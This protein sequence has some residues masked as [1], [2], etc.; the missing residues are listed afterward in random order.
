MRLVRDGVDLLAGRTVIGS[1]T[2]AEIP[3]DLTPPVAAAVPRE[4]T[5]PY[6]HVVSSTVSGR[7]LKVIVDY[8]REGDF[9]HLL[10]QGSA[11]RSMHGLA[12]ARTYRVWFLVPPIGTTIYMISETKGQSFAGEAL[13][14]RLR[15]ENQRQACT[16]N[17][18][19]LDVDRWIRWKYE[20]L[21]DGQRIQ[22]IFNGADEFELKVRRVSHSPG[23]APQS[24]TVTITENGLSHGNTQGAIAAVRGWWNDRRAGTTVSRSERAARDIGSLIDLNLNFQQLGFNDGEIRFKQDGKVQMI[25]PNKIERLFVYPMGE[26]PP[27]DRDLTVKAAGRLSNISRD[28]SVN[29]DLSDLL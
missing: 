27:H 9:D 15:V 24:G 3:A 4:S 23:G 22:D 16:P 28:L 21:F 5:R 2:Y 13:V 8:G 17:G 25:N 29:V 1:P 11:P 26:A 7:K 6:L 14:D 20:P 12:A 18:A 19:A 10:S